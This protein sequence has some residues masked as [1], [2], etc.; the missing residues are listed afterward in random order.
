MVTSTIFPSKTYIFALGIEA[1][2]LFGPQ[3]QKDCSGKPDSC[4]GYREENA[5]IKSQLIFPD[6]HS[7]KEI[8]SP[9]VV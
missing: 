5:Q 3:G 6:Y 9:I 4:D 8:P 1:K 2:I 7:T